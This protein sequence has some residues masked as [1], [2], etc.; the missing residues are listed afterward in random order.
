MVVFKNM[1]KLFKKVII[2]FF[3][4]IFVLPLFKAN[5]YVSVKGYY[6]SNGTYVAPYV[7]SNPNGLKYDNYGY[8]PSQ[9]LYNGT[10][11]TRG[12]TW[13]TPTY[14]T[15]PNYYTGKSLYDSNQTSLYSSPSYNFYTPDTTPSCP[16]M[17]SYDST[18][19]TCKCYSGYSVST[20]LLGK[21]A[22]ISNISNCQ[23]L[24]GYNSTYNSLTNTCECLHNYIYNGKECVSGST[25]CRDLIG[26][27]SSYNS[28]TKKCECMSNY[29]LIGSIC[30]YKTNY[31][32]N[33]STDIPN[34]N[35][36]SIIT[37]P[38]NSQLKT[39]NK[40]YCN[41]GYETN[42]AKDGCTM[43]CQKNSTLISGQC[44]CDDDFILINS[45]CITHTDNC[46]LSFGEYV[47]GV[48]GD[49][50]NSSCSC[51]YDYV[52]NDDRTAC[53][54]INKPISIIEKEKKLTTN[55]DKI[56]SKKQAGKIFAQNEEGFLIWYVNPKDN[57][58][59]LINS[60]SDLLNIIQKTGKF[61]DARQ[62]EA[63]KKS[64]VKFIGN[65]IIDKTNWKYYYVNL[66]DKKFYEV[67][68]KHNGYDDYE[69]GFQ[70]LKKLG[71]GITNSDIRKITVGSWE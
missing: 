71:I 39:D 36:T 26:L 9:G 55:V 29:E 70:F 45:N 46:E 3:A 22:C 68:P 13:D 33:Y 16:S 7:R 69:A 25:Y 24:N 54:F 18:S 11:G 52:W 30:T 67:A 2:L 51:L 28:L 14:I 27:M 60:A 20:D 5:A 6:K 57:K 47:S 1:K 58:R 56:F 8:T 19:K 23:K 64:P 32:Y 42:V 48:K 62:T 44:V 38:I 43:S 17:S 15:D 4:I 34:S 12:A 66:K 40:C 35:N 41:S 37:C 63:A 61:L 49:N 59:Y 31:S 53:I 65:F 50:N 10:Y 21:E